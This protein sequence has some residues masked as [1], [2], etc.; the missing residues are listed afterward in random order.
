[1]Y[2]QKTPNSSEEINHKT[3]LY[4]GTL[5]DFPPCFPVELGYHNVTFDGH[6][7]PDININPTNVKAGM[8]IS[9]RTK[10]ISQINLIVSTWVMERKRGTDLLPLSLKR[11]WLLGSAIRELVNQFKKPLFF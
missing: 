3:S 2:C 11:F 5:S 7:H 6:H 4:I 1:M 9:I 8:G 10:K